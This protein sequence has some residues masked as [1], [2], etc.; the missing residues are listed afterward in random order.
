MLHQNASNDFQRGKLGTIRPCGNLRDVPPRRTFPKKRELH[1]DVTADGPRLVRYVAAIRALIKDMHRSGSG[2]RTVALVGGEA[3]AL[4]GRELGYRF[5]YDGTSDLFEG[6]KVTIVIGGRNVDGRIVTVSNHALTVSVDEDFGPTIGACVI[7][8]DNTAMIEALADRLEKITKGEK[9]LNLIIAEDAVANT[10]DEQLPGHVPQHLGGKLNDKQRE[11][12]GLIRANTVTYLWGPPGT[13][14]TESLSVANQLLFEAGKRTL[15]C[16]NTNQAVDQVLLKLCNTLGKDHPAMAGVKVVRLGQIHHGELS[17]KYSEYVTLD[18]IVAR[19][20][21]DLRKRKTDLEDQID[22]T[23][24]EVE[25]AVRLLE[26]F[27][28][29]DEAERRR[30]EMEYRRQALEKAHNDASSAALAAARKIG[31]LERELRKRV[32]VGALRRLLLRSEQNIKADI[33]QAQSADSEANQRVKEYEEALASDERKRRE[34]DTESLCLQL[35]QEVSGANRPAAQKQVDEAQGKIQPLI[36]EVSEIDRKLEA[37]EKAVVTEAR[38]IG[39]TVTKTFLSPQ[40]FSNFDAVIIDEASMVMLPAVFYASGLAKEKVVIS[41]DFRQLSPIVPTDQAAILDVIGADVFYAAGI[42]AAFGEKRELKRTVMLEYQYRMSAGICDLIS[43][44]MYDRRLKTACAET[45]RPTAPPPPFEGELTIIDTSPIQPFVN[46]HGSSRYNLMHALAVRNLSRYL[47]DGGF[48][49]AAGCLGICTPFAAQKDVLLRVLKGWGLDG[50]VETGTVH[51]YQ[52][53]EKVAMVIDIPDSVGQR[54]VGMFAQAEHPDE[55]GCKL[56]NVAISRA[57]SHLIFIANLNYLDR[58]LPGHAF[59]REIL[60]SAQTWGR[61]VDVR[62]VL[63]MWPIANDLPDLRRPFIL[64]PETL[65]SGLFRQTDFEAV[66]GTDIEAA[67]KSI[68]MFSGFVTPQRVAAYEPRFRR[69]LAEGVAI[70]CVTRPPKHNGTISEDLG[71]DALDGLEAMGCVVDTRWDIHEKVVIIDDEIVW[72]GSLN[73]LSHTNK[74][75]EMMARFSARPMA[76][77]LSA[78][79]AL[80]RSV[81]PDKAEGLS[82]ARE[83]PRCPEC[84]C[85]TTYR[86]GTHGAFWQCERECGWTQNV[87]KTK[88]AARLQRA[89]MSANPTFATKVAEL[90]QNEMARLS[91]AVAPRIETFRA[92]TCDMLRVEVAAMLDRLGHHVVSSAG[93]I[94]TEKGGQKFI[95]ACAIP[96]DTTPTGIA[97]VRRLHGA[98]VANGAARGFYITPHRFAPEAIHYAASA[99]LDLIDGPL[100]IKAMRKSRNEMN[101]PT[102]YRAMC[103]LCGAIVQHDLDREQAILCG[104]GHP[105]PPSIARAALVPYLAPKQRDQES[106]TG[107]YPEVR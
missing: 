96:T 32:A 14:K 76:L 23:R 66:C 42:T 59:L 29:L 18:G 27:R 99:P 4:D 12:V 72:F 55:N 30:Q 40:H 61:I 25:R 21:A 5:A 7:R 60:H 107:L 80:G 85:R 97:A 34:A 11:A 87:G 106:T 84:G 10:G 9:E 39:A 35:R 94:V 67:K 83:N 75:D 65:R 28:S 24:R 56:F 100:L 74:S 16:S 73:P 53:D 88:G 1:L 6:A 58:K 15:I 43:P 78:F 33:S 89:P 93:D 63:A 47:Q 71:R 69:K 79:M 36:Q 50:M 82:V 2:M 22:R 102:T 31:D 70:R 17:S 49:R 77:Q 38:I 8:V 86:T 91:A 26:R 54:Y 68:A 20:S 19:K 105:V 13:G 48:V 51:R 62:D 57:K 45:E 3:V 104:N 52:G 103:A 90:R 44:R 64:D 95:T 41:G 92:M 81:N 46:K 101:V 37:I 98:I